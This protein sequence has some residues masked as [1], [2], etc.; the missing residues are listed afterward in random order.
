MK[1]KKLD[2]IDRLD[3]MN[4]MDEKLQKPDEILYL[5]ISFLCDIYWK[6]F[7]KAP[8]ILLDEFDV[9]ITHIYEKISSQIV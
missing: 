4:Y 1:N 3:F 6:T 5:A 8:I 9:P 7:K 2:D